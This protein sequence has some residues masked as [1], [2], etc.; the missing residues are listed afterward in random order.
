MPNRF[1]KYTYVRITYICM[2]YKR[3]K[4]LQ[5]LQNTSLTLMHQVNSVD[6]VQTELCSLK[7]TKGVRVLQK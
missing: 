6:E 7:N 3:M 5:K 1:T 2:H 4:N